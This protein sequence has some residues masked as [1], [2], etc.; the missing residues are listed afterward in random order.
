MLGSDRKAMF[1]FNRGSHREL[2]TQKRQDSEKAGQLKTRLRDRITNLERVMWPQ[3]HLT[4][5]SI[6]VTPAT[7]KRGS[8]SRNKLNS[9][10]C[11]SC[12]AVCHHTVILTVR[13]Q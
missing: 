1:S 6:L 9:H 10:C 2:G 13:V 12:G 11:E 5:S 8:I 4:L 7:F 3:Q